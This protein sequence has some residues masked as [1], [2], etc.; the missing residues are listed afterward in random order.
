MKL[1]K[2]QYCITVE[3]MDDVVTHIS[4]PKS[5]GQWHMAIKADPP[6]QRMPWEPCGSQPPAPTCVVWNFKEC[7]ATASAVK[8]RLYRALSPY[9]CPTVTPCWWGL[10]RPKQLS[11]A[12]TARVIWLCACVRYWPDRGL[13]FECVTC[14]YCCFIW[15]SLE[16]NLKLSAPLNCKIT[17]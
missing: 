9:F 1:Q 2:L 11:M 10:T 14:F 5:R 7:F 3:W 4:K 12:A 6:S 16:R 15:N 8:G 17:R 13:V